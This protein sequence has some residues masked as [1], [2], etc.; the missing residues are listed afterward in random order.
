[1]KKSTSSIK[2]K[3]TI[4]PKTTLNTNQF[5]SLNILNMDLSNIFDLFQSLVRNCY[6]NYDNFITDNSFSIL[7]TQTSHPVLQDNLLLQLH[8]LNVPYNNKIC[9]YII[10]NIDNN[11]FLTGKIEEHCDILSITELEFNE[12]LNIIQTLEPDGVGTKNSLDAI[13]IQLKK[14][15][16]YFAIKLLTKYAKYIET[17]NLEAIIELEKCSLD[18]INDALYIIKNDTNPFPGLCYIDYPDNNTQVI[19]PDFILS[20]EDNNLVLSPSKETSYLNEINLN[21][22]ILKNSKFKEYMK[23]ASFTI[24]CLTRRNTTLLLITN[25]IISIQKDYFLNGKPLN[26]CTMQSI[27]NKTGMNVSTISRSIQNKY[28]QFNDEIISI[29]SLFVSKLSNEK[30]DQILKELKNIINEENKL[31]PYSD[32]DLYLILKKR[33]FK[34]SR[35]TITKYRDILNIPNSRNRRLIE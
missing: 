20:I 8:T 12:Q 16:Q 21:S 7:E 13:L 6:F 5:N 10:E 4:K 34:I 9:T 22:E 14:D 33:N 35:R 31:Y 17:N 23:N 11:G 25:E 18:D 24:E 29:R 15:D 1:M 30:D 26:R 32:Y 28:I 19:I 3:Q 2:T 27:A